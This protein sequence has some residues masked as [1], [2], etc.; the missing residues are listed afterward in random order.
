MILSVDIP[1]TINR[2]L[3]A[4]KRKTGKSK[5]LIVRDIIKA[6]FEQ[7]KADRKEVA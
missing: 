1:D 5:S 6:N 4:M 7:V 3:E 2:K